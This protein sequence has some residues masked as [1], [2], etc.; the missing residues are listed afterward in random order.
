MF[1]GFGPATQPGNLVE[2]KK[3][4]FEISFSEIVCKI[5]RALSQPK[6]DGIRLGIEYF[7]KSLSY[8]PN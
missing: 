3:E 8:K 6:N 4:K 1:S 7:S 5:M 2:R